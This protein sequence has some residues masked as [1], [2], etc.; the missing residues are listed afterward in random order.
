MYITFWLVSRFNS[1]NKNNFT[2][3][4]DDSTVLTCVEYRKMVHFIHWSSHFNLFSQLYS[5]TT[6]ILSITLRNKSAVLKCRISEMLPL[7]GN[8]ILK[9][10]N[11][12][13]LS[14]ENKNNFLNIKN[15]STVLNCVEYWKMVPVELNTLHWYH[16]ST[17]FL[18]CFQ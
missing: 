1:I 16:T 17:D 10:L 2:N 15:D 7:R 8:K 12:F 14:I 11:S 6:I 3:I 5:K 9:A 4:K 18:S 13:F